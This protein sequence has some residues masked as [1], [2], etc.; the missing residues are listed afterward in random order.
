MRVHMRVLASISLTRCELQRTFMSRDVS[1]SRPSSVYGLQTRV[2]SGFESPRLHWVHS[3]RRTR[4]DHPQPPRRTGTVSRRQDDMRSS[5]LSRVSRTPRL[6]ARTSS[7]ISWRC[8]TDNRGHMATSQEMPTCAAP[9]R[10][11]RAYLV[12]VGRAVFISP[13]ESATCAA[14]SCSLPT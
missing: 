8:G 2:F 11:V 12:L 13:F 1:V 4:R 9:G 14:S 5:R 10:A 6:R 3:P 7:T